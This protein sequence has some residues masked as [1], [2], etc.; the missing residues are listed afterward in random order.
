MRNIQLIIGVTL[1]VVLLGSCDSKER[2]AQQMAANYLKGV[3]FHF[4]S[5]EPL[6]TKVDSSF[7]SLC[8]DSEAI[9]LALEML[10]MFEKAQE[11]VEKIEDAEHAM[12]IW[13]PDRFYSSAFSRGEY[14]RAQEKYEDNK[15]HLDKIRNRIQDQ[16]SLIKQRQSHIKDGTFG[17]WKV[18][19]KFKSLNG[20][21]TVD[22]FGEYIFFCDT[23]FNEK[24]AYSKEEYDA[25]SKI[26]ETIAMSNDL[27]DLSENIQ[28][29]IL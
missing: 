14:R 28:N 20:A 18:Y 8:N 27:A 3:L 11:Y 16:F 19:H 7:V 13:A 6:Q 10:K 12:E 1:S 29:L 21:Q 24:A 23:E 17:G 15:K 26:M 22:L 9:T 5:Y 4:D 25:L 2:K